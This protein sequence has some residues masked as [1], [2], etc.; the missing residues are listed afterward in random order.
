MKFSWVI[1]LGKTIKNNA[2]I[3]GGA[4]LVNLIETR[5]D[6]MPEEYKWLNLVIGGLVAYSI[7]NKATFKE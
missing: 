4:A 6:W 2:I 1:N 5:A 7:K 3:L